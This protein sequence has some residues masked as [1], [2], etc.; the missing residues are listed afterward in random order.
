VTFQFVAQCLNHRATACPIN[1]YGNYAN[2][3]ETFFSESESTDKKVY[4][5]FHA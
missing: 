3:F 5:D 1:D 2:V 4:S